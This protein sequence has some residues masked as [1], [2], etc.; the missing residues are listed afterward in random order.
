M[1]TLLDDDVLVSI[2][3]QYDGNTEGEEEGEPV[4]EE[5]GGVGETEDDGFDEDD[6]DS[7]A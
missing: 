6:A 5:L 7:D 1:A 4:E 2:M 3:N